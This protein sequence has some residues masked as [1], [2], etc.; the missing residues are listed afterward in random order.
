MPQP[1]DQIGAPARHRNWAAFAHVAAWLEIKGAPDRQCRLGAVGPS[2]S[3][4]PAGLF[5]SRYGFQKGEQGVRICTAQL[6][7][8][9]VGKRRVQQPLV[10]RTT[11]VYG[12]PEI[13]GR[14]GA[15]AA[16]AVGRQVAGVDRSKW[17]L[18]AATSCIAGPSRGRVAALAVAYASQVGTAGRQV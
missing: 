14:P 1:I 13:I 18:Y 10:F 2:Q 6:S 11:F 4:R 17:C 7:E 3:V 9:G 15:N 8:A 16:V 5:D 12:L